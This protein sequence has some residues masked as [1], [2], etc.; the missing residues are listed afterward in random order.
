MGER[1]VEH[2][3][4]FQS[5][6]RKRGPK[7]EP[8]DG[9]SAE[10]I[11]AAAERLLERRGYSLM[12]LAQI[13]AEAKVSRPTVYRYFRDKEDVVWVITERAGGHLLELMAEVASGSAVPTKQLAELIRRHVRIL[14]EHRI[15]FRLA[16]RTGLTL[17]RER[18]ALLLSQERR[19]V[20][21]VANVLES[22]IKQQEFRPVNPVVAAHAIIGMANSVLDWFREDGPLPIDQVAEDLVGMALRSLA[23]DG[24]SP[25]G[26]LAR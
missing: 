9:R 10:R 19:Y 11:L 24:S 16:L 7:P 12:S 14:V 6:S 22:G 1:P 13:A 4:R 8:A 17:N 3:G 23:L 18:R 26:V 21:F 2:P 20:R 25:P 15:L 5:T